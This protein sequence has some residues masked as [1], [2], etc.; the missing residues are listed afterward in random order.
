VSDAEHT[1]GQVYPIRGGKDGT[2][3]PDGLPRRLAAIVAADIAG[4]SR[5]MGRDEEGTHARIKRHRRELL[6]HPSRSTTGS[7][8]NIPVMVSGDVR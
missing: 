5:L 8:S 4:Y 1:R 2:L 7:S 6:S 3:P